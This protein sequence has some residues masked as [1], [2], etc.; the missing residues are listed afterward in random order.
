MQV[1]ADESQLPLPEAQSDIKFSRAKYFN[2][3]GVL[4]IEEELETNVNGSISEKIKQV[5]DNDGDIEMN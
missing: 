5:S 2:K 1:A 4:E 3:N